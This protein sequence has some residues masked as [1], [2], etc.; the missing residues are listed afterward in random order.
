MDPCSWGSP[1]LSVQQ[2]QVRNQLPEEQKCVE[3]LSTMHTLEAIKKKCIVPFKMSINSIWKKES[4][5]KIYSTMKQ[6]E[7]M[8]TWGHLRNFEIVFN[9][10][11]TK[12]LLFFFITLSKST[13]FKYPQ[14]FPAK[15]KV[16]PTLLIHNRNKGNWHFQV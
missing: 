10:K 14:V 4:P 2:K 7:K 11:E 13:N 12:K 6:I 16:C 1:F 3:F 9:K 8:Q 5:Q 15:I